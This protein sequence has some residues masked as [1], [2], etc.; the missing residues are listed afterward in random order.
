MAGVSSRGEW[1]ALTQ[2]PARKARFG[3]AAGGGHKVAPGGRSQVSEC[4]WKIDSGAA[5]EEKSGSVEAAGVKRTSNHPISLTGLRWTP[6]PR[7]RAMSWEPRQ[8][9]R[10]GWPAAMAWEMS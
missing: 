1:K 3:Q 7:T 4:Q 5:R 2:G 6:A 9:P 8:M 10:S